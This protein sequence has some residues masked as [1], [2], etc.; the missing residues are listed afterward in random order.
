M[1]IKRISVRIEYELH[2]ALK[3]IGLEDDITL[4]EMFLDAVKEKYQDR[5]VEIQ[6]RTNK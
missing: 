1:S 6:D 3:Y 2:N 5:I 4:Q